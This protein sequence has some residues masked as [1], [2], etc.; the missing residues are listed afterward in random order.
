MN[1]PFRCFGNDP[2]YHAYHDHEWGRPVHNDN[3]L[4]EMLIL[5]GAQ[6]G[7]SWITVLR[8]REAYRAAFD[9]FDPQK[10]ACYDQAKV[11]ELLQNPGIIRNQLKI[12]SS[13]R[14]AQLFLK[15]Q[16]EFGSFDRFI[17]AYVK[18]R[19]IIGSWEHLDQ[20]PSTTALSERIS[21]DLKKRGFGFVGP[22]IIYSFMQAVGL[23]ND[24]LLGCRVHDEV[25]VLSLN[26]S[27]QAGMKLRS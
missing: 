13:I 23:V 24:H 25:K 8:K 4:F 16:E 15:V 2:L 14:N 10:V 9:G 18:G 22:T 11:Q 7:L 21:Q 17:W 6:A 26:E 12:R 20:V 19:P 3:K 5:E 27:A 1:T